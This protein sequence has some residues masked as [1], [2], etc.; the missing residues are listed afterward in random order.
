MTIANLKHSTD[1]LKVSI[2][3]IASVWLVWAGAVFADA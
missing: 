1:H 2:E 3:Q